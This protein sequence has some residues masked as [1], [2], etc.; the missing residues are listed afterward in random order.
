MLIN[1]ALK[2]ATGIIALI[3][4]VG[5]G[6]PRVASNADGGST[7][8][9]SAEQ[10]PANK[11][12]QVCAACHQATGVG[13]EG[14]FPP[15]AGS[16]WVTGRADI[17]I[18][19]VLHGLQ[20]PI[21]VSGKTYNSAMTPWATVMSDA[22]IAATLTYARSSWGNRASAV[23]TVQVRAVRARF[24]TRT[25]PWTATELRAIR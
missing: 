24:S 4:S 7:H 15:L 19:I 20:G 6:A 17:P 18:A 2:V 12:E 13:V 10:Q 21:E 8:T 3:V 23:T 5:L 22:E 14:A 1:V 11:Y 25:T 16:S 9:A